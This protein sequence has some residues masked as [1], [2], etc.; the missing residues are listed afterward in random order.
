MCLIGSKRNS[1][2]LKY[3]SQFL[4]SFFAMVVN[5]NKEILVVQEKYYK[6]PHW[7]LPGGYVDPGNSIT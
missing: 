6:T 5:K 4:C 2:S 3:L 7:K 1:A